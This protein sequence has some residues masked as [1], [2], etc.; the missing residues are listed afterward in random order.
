MVRD[1]MVALFA[2]A[3][4][5]TI[6][7]LVANSYRLATG[8]R[9]QT[10]LLSNIALMALAG[11]NVLFGTATASLRARNSSGFAFCLAAGVSSYWSFVIGL[12]LLNLVV[13]LQPR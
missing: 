11:P 1:L 8:E 10:K 4:G 9:E 12:F 6:S 7:G 13:V 3:A 2:I 5:F